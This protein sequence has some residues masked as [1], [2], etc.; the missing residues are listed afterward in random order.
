MADSVA[1]KH[2]RHVRD[3]LNLLNAVRDE[4]LFDSIA[5]IDDLT[6]EVRE[7]NVVHTS[8]LFENLADNADA[9]ILI[10]TGSESLHIRKAISSGGP[11]FYRFFSGTEVSDDGTALTKH[12]RNQDFGDANGA[13]LFHSPTVTSTGTEL[14]VELIL[15]STGGPGRITPVGAAGIDTAVWILEAN[16]NYLIRFTNKAGESINMSYSMDHY[17]APS[18]D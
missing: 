1:E 6:R 9:D 17:T 16:T 3:I 18:R 5:T 12:N 11:G 10:K 13:S 4:G 7:G 8:H 14:S 2:Y 15:G